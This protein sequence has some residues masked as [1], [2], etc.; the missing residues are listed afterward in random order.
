[1]TTKIADPGNIRDLKKKV[2]SILKTDVGKGAFNNRYGRDFSYDEL[3][4]LID[5]R[6]CIWVAYAD[7]G[8]LVGF[9]EMWSKDN[10]SSE[11]GYI[12]FPEYQK[13]GFGYNLAK[14]IFEDARKTLKLKH[15]RAETEDDNVGSMRILKRLGDEFS[16]S[17]IEI[18][19]KYTPP[20]VVYEWKVD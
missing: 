14:K 4:T 7:T 2:R 9:G 13:L 15:I 18:N 17:K 1:M 10:T 19:E 12:I 20:T 11:F 3:S 5:G 16:P 8:D 6:Q